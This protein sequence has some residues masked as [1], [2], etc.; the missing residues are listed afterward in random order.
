MRKLGACQWGARWQGGK[1][2]VAR[3]TVGT[4]LAGDPPHR[5]VRELLAHM[6][7][8]SGAW[9]GTARTLS[10]PLDARPRLG[11]RSAGGW[12]G[13][14]GISRFSNIEFP[15]MPGPSSPWGR[16]ATRL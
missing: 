2:L 8:T 14:T 6:A 7:P 15:H 11:V 12:R 10:S 13:A 4:A 3:F 16:T 1:V 5:S 9:R